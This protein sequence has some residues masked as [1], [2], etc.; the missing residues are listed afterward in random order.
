MRGK[1][2][3]GGLGERQGDS[4]SMLAGLVQRRKLYRRLASSGGGW[5]QRSFE[6]GALR[7]FSGMRREPGVLG[8]LYRAREGASGSR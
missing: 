5:V 4:G 6:G 3:L 8:G 7:R 1:N 2:L